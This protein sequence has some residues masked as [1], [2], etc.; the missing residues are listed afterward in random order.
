[1]AS[2]EKVVRLGELA[3]AIDA[4]AS[5]G[6]ALLLKGGTPINLAFG[7]PS[8]LSVDLDY[9][10]VGAVERAAMLAMR[11]KVEGTIE[12]ICMRMAYSVQ[13]SSEAHAGHKFFLHYDGADGTPDRLEVD[14]SYLWREPIAGSTRHRLWQPGGLDPVAVS[15][16]SDLELIVGKT[17]A[18][19]DRAAP[20]DA[21][22]V[23]N[24]DEAMAAELQSEFGRTWLIALSA[25]LPHS[26]DRYSLDRTARLLTQEV[27]TARLVPMLAGMSEVDAKALA[28]TAWAKVEPMITLRGEEALYL[29]G[30]QRGEI[31]AELLFPKDPEAAE[32][33]ANHPAVRWKVRNVLGRG[34]A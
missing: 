8:R 1:M 18:F 4:D 21:W 10:F 16:V 3:R 32:R 31:R 25:M 7:A 2:L 29:A 19:L 9:N 20:R 30:I 27:I 33:L 11:P 6:S 5:L 26:I 15:C 28:E 13:H 34:G 12:S 17:L 22:D 23:A 24:L 14:V